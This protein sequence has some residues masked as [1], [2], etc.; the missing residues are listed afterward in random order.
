MQGTSRSR[1][2]AVMP[3]TQ[4]AA[5]SSCPL[6]PLVEVDRWHTSRARSSEHEFETSSSKGS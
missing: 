1:P 5:R 4:P 3:S 2:G 6:H